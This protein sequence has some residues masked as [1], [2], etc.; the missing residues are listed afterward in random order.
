M[1][2]LLLLSVALAAA[3][4]ALAE[5]PAAAAH[6]SPR[7]WGPAEVTRKPA[8]GVVVWARPP[9]NCTGPAAL[10]LPSLPALRLSAL[11]LLLGG[12]GAVAG[13]GSATLPTPVALPSDALAQVRGRKAGLVWRRCCCLC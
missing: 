3:L 8:P 5:T 6:V 10:R 11:R 9:G 12:R 7:F 2:A 4:L 1:N 13:A